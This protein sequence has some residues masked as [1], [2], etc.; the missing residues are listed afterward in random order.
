M[1]I[2][3]EPAK[4]QL[5]DRYHAMAR[6]AQRVVP[7]WHGAVVRVGVVPVADLMRVLAR[8]EAGARRD[9]DRRGGVRVSE[10]GAARSEPIEVRGLREGMAGGAHDARVVLVGHEDQKIL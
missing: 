10:P 7:A 5:A 9:A 3:G 8:R 1:I 4:V 2:A 6:G